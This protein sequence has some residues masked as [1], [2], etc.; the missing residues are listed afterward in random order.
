[1]EY[2]QRLHESKGHRPWSSRSSTLSPRPFAAASQGPLLDQ[3]EQQGLAARCQ[4]EGEFTMSKK[5]E[6]NKKPLEL[7]IKIKVGRKD[8]DALVR[9]LI[10]QQQ[11]LLSVADSVKYMPHFPMEWLRKTGFWSHGLTGKSAHAK[12]GRLIGRQHSHKGDGRYRMHNGHCSALAL[13]AS[14]ANDP[15]RASWSHEF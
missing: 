15:K 9:L 4:I 2:H 3:C 11:E 1:M 10:K 14:V 7:T 8:P 6:V 5:P 13:N 12:W